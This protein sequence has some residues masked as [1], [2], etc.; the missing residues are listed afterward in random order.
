MTTTAP[1]IGREVVASTNGGNLTSPP[2][3]CRPLLVGVVIAQIR[4]CTL[5]EDDALW[6]EGCSVWATVAQSMVTPLLEGGDRSGDV[7][8]AALAPSQVRAGDEAADHGEAGTGKKPQN[9]IIIFN[10]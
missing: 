10:F 7:A 8:P 3:S 1:S 6:K 2:Q 9:I 4:G 5:L